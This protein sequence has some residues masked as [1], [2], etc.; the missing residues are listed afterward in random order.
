MYMLDNSNMI[1]WNLPAGS[2][3]CSFEWLHFDRHKLLDCL[4]GDSVVTVLLLCY[5]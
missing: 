5:G 2:A 3:Y 4:Q 1:I